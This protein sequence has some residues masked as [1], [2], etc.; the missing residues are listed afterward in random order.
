MGK[1]LSLSY[2]KV[3]FF[4]LLVVLELGTFVVFRVL[5]ICIFHQTY[6]VVR[7]NQAL[8]THR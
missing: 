6:Q 5:A 8:A 7:P 4:F 3:S 2:E 1:L